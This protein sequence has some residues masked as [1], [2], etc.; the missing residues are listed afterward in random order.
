MWVKCRLVCPL[1]RLQGH[2]PI[3]RRN[4]RGFPWAVQWCHIGVCA[5]ST[6]RPECG[7]L[8]SVQSQESLVRQ[9]SPVCHFCA[10]GGGGLPVLQEATIGASKDQVGPKTSSYDCCCH[11]KFSFLRLKK[12]LLLGSGLCKTLLGF[13]QFVQHACI[14]RGDLAGQLHYEA[15]SCVF[16]WA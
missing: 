4:V 14:D 9:G 12:P 3:R 13:S 5:K 16:V 1:R 2:W 7:L 15:A 11:S 8:N 6:F 10:G